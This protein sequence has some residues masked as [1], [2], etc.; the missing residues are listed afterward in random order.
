MPFR[1]HE[2]FL[3]NVHGLCVTLTVIGPQPGVLDHHGRTHEHLAAESQRDL[4]R[5]HQRCRIRDAVACRV[6]FPARTYPA[7]RRAA[8]YLQSITGLLSFVFAASPWCAFRA[9]RRHLSH[10][11]LRFS[12]SGTVL[13]ASSVLFFQLSQDAPMPFRWAPLAWWSAEW[14]WRCF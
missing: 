6:F 13:M 2:K 10:S 8:S 4:S 3:R 11:R 12:L 7:G 1:Q 14:C 5:R 9:R